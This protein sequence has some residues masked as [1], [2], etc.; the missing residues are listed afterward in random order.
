MSMDDSKLPP[1]VP[2]DLFGRDDMAPDD[3]SQM[4][5]ES[6]SEEED[7]SEDEEMG[8][9]ENPFLPRTSSMIES[10]FPAT[11][12][13]PATSPATISETTMPTTTSSYILS[14]LTDNPFIPI[15]TV[16]S[17]ATPT[18]PVTSTVAA[19]L[20]S[21]AILS[22]TFAVGTN[23]AATTSASTPNA[24]AEASTSQRTS[25]HT[26]TAIAVGTTV[27]VLSIVA[28]AFLLLRYCTP[29][30]A[31]VA[32]Y[33]GR[34]G[35]RLP[36][37]EER[38]G[39]PRRMALGMSQAYSPN[40]MGVSQFSVNA[41]SAV[42]TPASTFTGATAV[43][44]PVT[45]TRVPPPVLVRNTSRRVNDV[46][47]P[48]SDPAPLARKGSSGG[49]TTSSTRRSLSTHMANE[50]DTGGPP[51][52]LSNVNG[53]GTYAFNFSF[54]E[55]AA[56]HVTGE[57]DRHPSGLGITMDTSSPRT[58]SP[59]TFTP[60]TPPESVI[61]SPRSQYQPQ[62]RKSITPS[63]SVSNAPS[64]PLPFPAEL[65]P[66]MPN[67]RWSRNSSSVNG[68]GATEE[69]TD[70]P[71]AGG[72]GI[73]TDPSL[74]SMNRG[75]SASSVPSKLSSG[76]I[77]TLRPGLPNGVRPPSGSESRQRNGSGSGTESAIRLP[78]MTYRP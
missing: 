12:S 55:Y 7:E 74:L 25:S 35:Q 48:F 16:T 63:E 27:G 54:D 72:D 64:S 26:T 58:P 59:A 47:N 37:D 77:P 38:A 46:E 62:I 4:D 68:R 71:S 9:D 67:S 78:A 15:S 29:V 61:D 2:D 50:D 45:T 10:A 34:R 33:R 17:S 57:P 69:K 31:R 13:Q 20:T 24:S 52:R 73:D 14:S 11:I 75:S 21:A 3:S 66:P 41:S 18:Y 19:E 1:T 70:M 5:D 49:S 43:G 56:S 6:D 44:L 53:N 22:T 60:P 76:S 23:A 51:T 28:M 32:A 39:S 8:D 65:V 42:G 36:G 30:K 40:P